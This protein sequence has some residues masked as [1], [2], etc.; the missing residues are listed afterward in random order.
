MQDALHCCPAAGTAQA[1]CQQA[2]RCWQQLWT[3]LHC[4]REG[5]SKPQPVSGNGCY[6]SQTKTDLIFEFSLGFKPPSESK[7]LSVWCAQPRRHGE[8]PLLVWVTAD[9]FHILETGWMIKIFLTYVC[10]HTHT[11]SYMPHLTYTDCKEPEQTL[12]ILKHIYRIP[13]WGQ[14]AVP[15][16]Q[17]GRNLGL[18]LPGW[19]LTTPGHP[20]THTR[21]QDQLAK[22]WWWSSAPARLKSMPDQLSCCGA[23]YSLLL[24]LSSQQ[25]TQGHPLWIYKLIAFISYLRNSHADSILMA[26]ANGVH[27]SVKVNSRLLPGFFFFLGYMMLKYKKHPKCY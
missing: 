19:S 5:A 10:I 11:Y 4:G 13:F 22:S 17:W 7:Y 6:C 27:K 1:N 23:G 15:S 2:Q 3:W 25:H 20:D 16:L 26:T 18:W 9:V 12:I 21:L 24:L 14:Q 8:Q